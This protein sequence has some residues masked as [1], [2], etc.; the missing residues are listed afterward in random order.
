MENNLD[1]LFKS[2]LEGQEPVFHPAAWDRMEGLLDKEGLAPT[3]KK[4]Y[5]R[6]RI[7][8]LSFFF[9]GLLSCVGYFMMDSV[10]NFGEGS[11]LV[12]S[13]T[14][15]NAK[16][17]VST[18]RTQ[19]SIRKEEATTKTN[20][21]TEIVSS[22]SDISSQP[23]TANTSL[24]TTSSNQLQ[25]NYTT[26]YEEKSTLANSKSKIS[27]SKSTQEK[28]Q[29]KT[30][31]SY[32]AS[33]AVV[34]ERSPLSN[35][36]EIISGLDTESNLLS[37]VNQDEVNK[38][39]DQM[40]DETFSSHSTGQDLN[41]AFRETKETNLDI[42]QTKT[43]LPSISILNTRSENLEFMAQIIQPQITKLETSKFEI[44]IL[45]SARFNQ[46]N[47]Y[48]FGPYLSYGLGKGISMNVG[49]MIDV[50]N[51]NQGPSV[52]VINK[53]YS[54]GSTISE[55]TFS[56]NYQTSISI[57]VSIQKSFGKFGISTGF[58]VNKI[59][60]SKGNI[61]QG[62]E[63][64]ESSVYVDSDMMRSTTFNF[65][66]GGSVNINRYF[67]FNV[68]IEY[69]QKSFLEDDSVLN[70]TN[71]FYPSLGLKYKLFRF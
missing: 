70:N 25:Q 43:L 44:G 3:V 26:Q 14:S 58:A 49:S 41:T 60:A 24:P 13:T 36:N 55:R 33:D 54:F 19:E 38:K 30:F 31:K 50:Q 21:N 45:T 42:L 7:I 62:A 34:V 22:R 15:P 40:E 1:K 20:S 29:S 71:N 57:P 4:K 6:S 2:K 63:V 52:T 46:G 12:E 53:V 37:S 23:S 28:A 56:L 17:D 16:T 66:V 65:Q 9:I 39:Q 59:L 67:D 61:A 18:I 5:N 47:G 8:Y 27:N 35:S 48:S 10:Q 11:S 64:Q 51:Y 68:G 69:R 32:L